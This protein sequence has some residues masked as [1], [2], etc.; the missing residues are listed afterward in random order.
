MEAGRI[1]ES[2]WK[3]FWT[4]YQIVPTANMMS[5]SGETSGRRIWKMTMLG[6]ATQPSAPLRAKTLAMFI[7]CLQ[8]PKRPAEAL[9]HQAIR[10]CRRFGISQRHVFV[11]DAI[12]PT[13]Q[14]HCQISVLGD[15][16]DVI[17]AGL[18]HRRHT[19]GPDRTGNHADGAEYPA[20]AARNSGW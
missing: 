17:A 14:R 4:K 13:Q 9:T 8:N 20:R 1:V 10:I 2:G 11:F 15:R 16:V 18:A 12:T 7:H 5:M 3:C 19:P 6:S